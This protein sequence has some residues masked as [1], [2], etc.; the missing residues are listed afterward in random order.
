M[1]VYALLNRHLALGPSTTTIPLLH[2]KTNDTFAHIN[3]RWQK[4]IS[5]IATIEIKKRN[6][7]CLTAQ[8]LQ[9]IQEQ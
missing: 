1:T 5:D 7:K 6:R 3:R 4:Y 9:N 8:N 2:F